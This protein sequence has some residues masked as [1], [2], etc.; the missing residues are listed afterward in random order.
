MSQRHRTDF[1]L[2]KSRR[3]AALARP[4]LLYDRKPLPVPESAIDAAIRAGRFTKLPP[5]RPRN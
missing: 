1:K 3:E 2:L 4:E 5:K